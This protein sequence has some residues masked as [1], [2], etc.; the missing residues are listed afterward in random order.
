MRPAAPVSLWERGIVGVLSLVVALAAGS[1]ALPARAQGSATAT[2][3][4]IPTT[5]PEGVEV[6]R[7]KGKTVTAMETEVPTSV[8]QF[9][10]AA[11]AALG[12]Q[13]ISDLAKVTPN[14][15][16]RTSGS[17]TAT[18]FVRGVGLSDF[19][20]NAAGAVAIYQDGVSM[21]TPALQLGQL[22]DL[23]NVD[24]LRGPQGSGPGRNASAGAIKIVSRKP[25]NDFEAAL[26]TELGISGEDP[27]T[28]AL[29]GQRDFEGA[30]QVPLVDE[31]LSSRF[32]FRFTEKDPFRKNGC[33]TRYLPTQ[34]ERE[35]DPVAWDRVP[36]CGQTTFPVSFLNPNPPPNRLRIARVDPVEGQHKVND[37]DN[38]A[39]RG[40][41]RFQPPD[42]NMDW[43]LNF[44]GSRL[45]QQS[46]VGQAIGTS[47]GFGGFTF[48]GYRDPDIVEMENRLLGQGL[49][50]VEARELVG[51]DLARN[52]DIRPYRG[53][54]NRQGQTRLDTWGTFVR[55]DLELGETL[56]LTTITSY[57][58]Y[59]RSRN[60][61]Q[62]FTSLVLFESLVDDS[63]W[64]VTQDLRLSGELEEYSL[65]WNVGGFYLQEEIDSDN[66]QFF[67]AAAGVLSVSSSVFTQRTWSFGTYAGFEMDFL[68]D[69]TLEFGVR[70]NWEKKDF[71]FDLVRGPNTRTQQES[72]TWDAPTGTLALSYRFTPEFQ[73][74][75]KLSR[76]W[77]GG[78]F[79]GSANLLQA[80]APAEPETITAFE[81]GFRGRMLDGRLDLS[82]TFF[83]YRYEDYQVFQ[84]ENNLGAPPLLLI[85]N[86]NDAE[87]LG[88]ELEL[89]L[90]PIE[91]LVPDVI[92][93]LALSTQ[94]AWLRSE[95]L[96]FTQTRIEPDG[97]VGVQEV[98]DD[99]SGNP[100]IN[101][102]EWKVVLGVEWPLD[103]G[104]YGLLIPRY[105]GVWTD[106]IYFDATQG[107]GIPDVDGDLLPEY[108]L[109]QRAHWIHN[110]RMA[111]QAPGG[112]FELAAWVRNFTDNVVKT[113]AFNA[114]RFSSVVINFV[115]EPRSYGLTLSFKY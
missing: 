112:Q 18:F 3:E 64:Q 78:H 20:A 45:D 91:D 22:F 76:G 23:A 2:E 17:T 53:D 44:H 65:R 10:P 66:L 40:Q 109:G 29:F 43:L 105:D 5:P 15:E 27:R 19:N 52:L 88:T 13:N 86:A 12:A 25:T 37:T 68:E 57:D 89:R 87:V 55:G 84:F 113:Y 9:D 59:D 62:D 95:F 99:F 39:A 38:W 11:I 46:T 100:L 48:G 80:I 69:F 41:L 83:Y 24:V 31:V 81:T 90:R 7:I 35:A 60:T 8:T 102:P 16:I 34:A 98:I 85:I 108:A 36:V 111:Y 97:L 1:A 71:D 47:Q 56:Q 75:T 92:D 51:R 54:Y 21:N 110:I 107:R 74:Y 72:R 70:Y 103:F 42:T 61:D 77:K 50:L 94:I 26:R 58:W 67:Q 104:R 6:I 14:V 30:L 93:G 101:S 73:I 96:D 33:S 4:A 28:G 115:G 32:A 63:A 79:N 114:S 106:D 49:T 82:G